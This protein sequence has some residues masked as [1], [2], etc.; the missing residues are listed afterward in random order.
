MSSKRDKEQRRL[1]KNKEETG[2]K[3]FGLIRSLIAAGA[4]ALAGLG[5]GY[6]KFTAKTPQETVEKRIEQEKLPGKYV[7]WME[8][9]G[10]DPSKRDIYF[11]FQ[12]HEYEGHNLE[13][14]LGNKTAEEMRKKVKEENCKVQAS[15][16]RVLESLNSQSKVDLVCE[17]AHLHTDMS[18]PGTVSKGLGEERMSKIRRMFSSDSLLEDKIRE[19]SIGLGGAGW[20]AA[21]IDTLYIGGWEDANHNRESMSLW[22]NKMKLH[23]VVTLYENCKNLP[24]DVVEKEWVDRGYSK[25]DASDLKAQFE[26]INANP[27]ELGKLR[28]EINRLDR[29]FEEMQVIR[30]MDAVNY[31]IKNADSL[32]D[33]GRTKTRNVAVVIGADHEKDYDFIKRDKGGKDYNAVFIHPKGLAEARPK[34]KGN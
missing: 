11:L 23:L 30:S 10:T 13:S 9:A 20:A 27:A 29:L 25:H 22:D 32:Y 8:R 1:Y 28:E 3:R 14:W 7:E 26:K 19:D 18:K 16:Y 33:S 12:T 6:Y 31:S 2:P 17:E 24:L 5:I 4:V 21:M 15:I 34:K